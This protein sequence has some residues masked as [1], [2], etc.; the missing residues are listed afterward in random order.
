[1]CLTPYRGVGPNSFSDFAGSGRDTLGNRT[2]LPRLKP[3]MN[4]GPEMSL[5]LLDAPGSCRDSNSKTP[6]GR[7]L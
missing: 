3:F 1:M 2:T 6:P 4:A 5:L 7:A